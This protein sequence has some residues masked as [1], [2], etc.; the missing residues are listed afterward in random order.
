MDQK[1][2]HGVMMKYETSTAKGSPTH[3]DVSLLL[4][5]ILTN[6]FKFTDFHFYFF[7][8]SAYCL[9]WSG[10]SS[11]CLLKTVHFYMNQIIRNYHLVKLLRNVMRL[12]LVDD[13]LKQPKNEAW[14]VG[15][16]EHSAVAD[17]IIIMIKDS[18]YE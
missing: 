10:P 14:N 5:R 18:N 7:V 6:I 11:S 9:V 16:F 1:R 4:F 15:H 2:D 12:K 8:Q 3:S 17:L 13:A